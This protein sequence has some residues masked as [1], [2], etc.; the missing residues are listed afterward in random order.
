MTLDIV[1]WWLKAKPVEQKEAV[2]ARQRHSKH[3]SAATDTDNRGCG[4]FCG[5]RKGYVMTSSSSQSV[6]GCK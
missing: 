2:S 5:L 6:V 1:T 4:V 3:F